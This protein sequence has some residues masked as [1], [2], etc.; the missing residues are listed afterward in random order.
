MKRKLHAPSRILVVEAAISQKTSLEKDQRIEL[1][2][3]IIAGLDKRALSA[4]AKR[5]KQLRD[6][7]RNEGKETE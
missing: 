1:A 3:A 2:R 4:K 5:R 7:K 6:A